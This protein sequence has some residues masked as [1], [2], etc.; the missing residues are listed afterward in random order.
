MRFVTM[1]SIEDNRFDILRV[2]AVAGAR[3]EDL[4]GA[5]Q[6]AL[7]AAAHYVG[8]TAA[9]LYLWDD[10]MEVTLN[11]SYAD[12]NDSKGRLAGLEEELFARLR[13]DKKLLSAYMS[14][15]GDVPYHSF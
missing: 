6:I 7:E 9:A 13:R 1:S 12:T 5:S 14:F 4:T 10:N 11:V 2:L 15:G 3:G 8:L